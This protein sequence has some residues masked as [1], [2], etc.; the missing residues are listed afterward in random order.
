VSTEDGAACRLLHDQAGP[1]AGVDRVHLEDVLLRNASARGARVEH[2]ALVRRIEERGDGALLEVVGAS[3]SRRV[4]TR[5]LVGADGPHSLVARSM[6]LGKR[7]QLP[8]LRRAGLTQHRQEPAALPPGAPMAAHLV[9][10]RGWYCGVTPVPGA[11]QNVG[12][13]VTPDLLRLRPVAI[14]ERVAARLPPAARGWVT[15]PAS[16]ELRVAYPLAHRP[17][18]LAATS[19]L[20]VGDAAGFIDP[21][22]GEG[23]R[24][25]FRSA[26]L[27]AGALVRADRGDPAALPG[28]DDRLRAEYRR[29]DLISYLFQAFMRRPATLGYVVRRLERR[30]NVRS[31]FGQVLSDLLP[32]ER[33]LEPRFV[34]AFL[35]P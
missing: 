28:Y 23:L 9:F 27:A 14:V 12:I 22:T 2:G 13:V 29:K 31:V 33:L 17:R 8:V 7:G 30:E 6:G 34:A 19:T 21:V 15:Q 4:A 5:W 3:G 16:D 10:G 25:A 26:E 24:R 11:R 32:A 20:L 18:R 1:A 35:A